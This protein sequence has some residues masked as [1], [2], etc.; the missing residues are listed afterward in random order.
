MGISDEAK[1][2]DD[3]AV[4]ARANV[5]EDDPF[6]VAARS[7]A[8]IQ[9]G[10]DETVASAKARLKTMREKVTDAMEAVGDFERP[11]RRARTL[12]RDAERD[13]AVATRRAGSSPPATPAERKAAQ[14]AIERR[15]KAKR[16]LVEIAAGR[17]DLKVKP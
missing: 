4:L 15:R 16:L 1:R 14:A 3:R 2:V 9:I 5:Y 10:K 17:I 13:V 11:L 7:Y 12:L 8:A 6:W